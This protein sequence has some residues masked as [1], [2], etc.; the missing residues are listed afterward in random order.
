MTITTSDDQTIYFEN[1]CNKEFYASVVSVEGT[2][3]T[4]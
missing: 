3:K 1:D 4:K 2:I